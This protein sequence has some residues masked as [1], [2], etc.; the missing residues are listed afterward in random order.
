MYGPRD[1]G[2]RYGEPYYK[3]FRNGKLVKNEED[4]FMHFQHRKSFFADN[5]DLDEVIQDIPSD[6]FDD[7]EYEELLHSYSD[8]GKL[9]NHARAK[10][11]QEQVQSV[12][13]K[14]NSMKKKFQSLSVVCD[15]VDS[16]EKYEEKLEEEP[17]SSSMKQLNKKLED[18]ERKRNTPKIHTNEFSYARNDATSNF[19]PKQYGV[20]LAEKRRRA[21]AIGKGQQACAGVSPSYGLSHEASPNR[22]L[23][24]QYDH[25][26]IPLRSRRNS[27]S[28]A[29]NATL[30]APKPE[31][32]DAS[33]QFG[34]SRIT[35]SPSVETDDE[36]QRDSGISTHD[37]EEHSSKSRKNKI[38]NRLK[39]ELLKPKF[40]LDDCGNLVRM[41][42][43]DS[44]EDS[45]FE[46]PSSKPS[47][48]VTTLSDQTTGPQTQGDDQPS[49]LVKIYYDLI[50]SSSRALF[51]FLKMSHI[52]FEAV[53]IQLR[54]G[55]HFQP[56]FLKLSPA[57][58]LPVMDDNGFVLR[59]AGAISRY[60]AAK[61]QLSSQWC[62][63]IDFQAH[64]RQDEYFHWHLSQLRPPCLQLFTQAMLAPILTKLPPNFKRLHCLKVELDSCCD[65]LESVFLQGPFI[66]G[67]QIGL[68][69]LF[70]V[71]ELM[72]PYGAGF[73]VRQGNSRRLRQWWDCVKNETKP[74]FDETH[75][76]MKKIWEN[77]GKVI[78]SQYDDYLM[79]L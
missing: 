26:A 67:N 20:S 34:R 29:T 64:A 43:E 23:S 17:E 7:L 58:K 52:D 75:E 62:P 25:S 60:L 3:H 56:D 55:D 15:Y 30:A 18:L 9:S 39:R 59:E 38:D 40:Y 10:E 27:F 76:E 48:S 13:D 45:V 21:A 66:N 37:E 79:S 51:I 50:S 44:L 57:K 61:H 46:S 54:N 19:P 24:A 42:S 8:G 4:P 78:G 6:S 33:T 70:A 47:T 65:Y 71:C 49:P 5:P 41:G 16:M 32:K 14:I 1:R 63:T 12:K 35:S 22:N 72:Q 73:D 28:M 36:K 11:Q 31:M 53:P 2:F 68:A 74:F 69:D 77:K